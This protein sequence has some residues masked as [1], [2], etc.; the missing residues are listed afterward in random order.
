MRR[1]IAVAAVLAAGGVVA[2]T[3]S[4]AADGPYHVVAECA[5]PAGPVSALDQTTYAFVA[6]VAAYSTN[7]SLGLGTSLTCY[8]Y[9]RSTDRI[10]ASVSQGTPGPDVAT[11]GTFTV[12]TTVDSALCVKANAVFSDGGAAGLNNCPF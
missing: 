1:A 11:V 4:A 12:P 8:L 9:D 2:P 3:A 10:Y 6:Y 5:T 7:G